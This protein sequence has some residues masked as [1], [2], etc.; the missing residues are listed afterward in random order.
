MYLIN[1]VNSNSARGEVQGRGDT[2][3]DNGNILD[4]NV[5]SI[6]KRTREI[7]GISG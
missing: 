1:G 2:D 5:K 6:S 3:T 4:V 7:K